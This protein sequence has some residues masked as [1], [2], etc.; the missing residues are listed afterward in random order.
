[1]KYPGKPFFGETKEMPE[2][3]LLRFERSLMFA[4]HY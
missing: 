4:H 3:N 1:M 2:I